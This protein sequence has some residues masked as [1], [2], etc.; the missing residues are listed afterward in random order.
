MN[1]LYDDL[2]AELDSLYVQKNTWGKRI[3]VNWFCLYIYSR[4][5]DVAMYIFIILIVIIVTLVGS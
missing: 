4:C 2:T 5:A 1:E 3:D